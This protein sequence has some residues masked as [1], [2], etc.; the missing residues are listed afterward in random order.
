MLFNPVITGMPKEA[1]DDTRV[2]RIGCLA[3]SI[4]TNP[5]IRYFSVSMMK[6]RISNR[7][8]IIA[9]YFLAFTSLVLAIYHTQL[10]LRLLDNG[11]RAEAVVTEIKRGARNSKWAVYRYNTETG[12]KVTAQDKFPMYIIHLHKGDHITLIYDPA[13]TG[14]VTADLGFWLWQG[15]IIFLFGFL[16]LAT[17]GVLI[18]RFKPK[19]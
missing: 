5:F 4:V 19:Q 1:G 8:G 11:R 7:A 12:R 16:F 2:L 10:L 3:L 9:C 17:T 13:D 18:L 15:P 6:A 14:M